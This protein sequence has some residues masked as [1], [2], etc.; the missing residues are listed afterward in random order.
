MREQFKRE[1]YKSGNNLSGFALKCGLS[2]FTLMD[3]IKEKHKS[4]NGSTIK[5]I[6]DGLGIT[7]EKAER[8]L[9][10]KN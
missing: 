10:V 5:A 1:I 8:V 6:A 9:N 4:V 7:Y 3:I 2:R